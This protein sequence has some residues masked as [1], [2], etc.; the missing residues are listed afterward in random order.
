[1]SGAAASGGTSGHGTA[2]P[3]ATSGD[4]PRATSGDLP[5]ATSGNRPRAI[6]TDI[7]GT[8]T[9]IAFVKEVLFPF[10][11]KHLPAFVKAHAADPEVR[12]CLDGARDL[13]GDRSLSDDAVIDV[14]IG[15]IDEDRKATPLKTLQGLIWADGY[16]SGE[17]K[18]HVYD[19]AA[20]HLRAWHAA[21]H[22]LFVFS[23]GSI[24]AQKLLFGHTSAGDL[25]GCFSG[26]FDT[27]TGPKLEA[28]SYVKI[29]AAIGR[30]PGEVLFL[31]DHAGELDAAAA[32]GMHTACLDRGEV[33]IPPDLRHPRYRSFAEIDPA[34]V[35]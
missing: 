7:E 8:T 4:L 16:A 21:G 29:A 13:A 32:A 12:A 19:D 20:E 9:S 25:T 30:P 33:V 1:M 15:W 6:V 18:S 31:S 26:W 3:A 11:R 14:L 28:A 24:A 23:S 2:E 22:A 35:A 5:R 17:L 10:A 34:S 27:T